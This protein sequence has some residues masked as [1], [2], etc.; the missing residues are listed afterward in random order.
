ML[1]GRHFGNVLTFVRLNRKSDDISGQVTMSHQLV[2]T[3]STYQ[4]LVAVFP[5]FLLA[6]LSPTPAVLGGIAGAVLLLLVHF[7]WQS[8]APKRTETIA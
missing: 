1:L 8:K 3:L 2:L 6:I 4:Y 7:V 5:I